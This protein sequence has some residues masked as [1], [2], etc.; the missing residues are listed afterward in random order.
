MN[1]GFKLYVTC[2][3]ALL[4][5][6]SISCNSSNSGSENTGSSTPNVQSDELDPVVNNYFTE[7]IVYEETGSENGIY[8]VGE[9]SI[10]VKPDIAVVNLGIQSERRTASRARKEASEN[11][12]QL[13]DAIKAV[14]VED[15]DIQTSY[16]NISPRYD[17]IEE[18]DEN[19]RKISRQVLVGYTVSNNVNVTIRN[20]DNVSKVIDSAAEASGDTIRINN[21]YFRVENTEEHEAELREL[22]Y[23][24]A[25]VKA[26]HF[27][28]MAAVELGE[29]IM[30]SEVNMSVAPVMSRNRMALGQTME[31]AGDYSTPISPGETDLNSRI[32]VFFQIK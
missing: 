26:K 8:V 32:S 3:I 18:K 29:V 22:A 24:D 25:L 19:G 5:I 1:S 9:G 12:Q 4:S 20:L 21:V 14:E 31:F 23:M 10:K 28:S 13:M 7:G 6:I 27:S 30:I 2:L 16:F 17:W 15:K 11:M